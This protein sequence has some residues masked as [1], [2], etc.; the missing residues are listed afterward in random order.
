MNLNNKLIN[1]SILCA[2]VILF[3]T[4]IAH[5]IINKAKITKKVVDEKNNSKE[6]A[7]E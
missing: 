3:L 5:G 6:G 7:N 4:G 2:L 1:Y